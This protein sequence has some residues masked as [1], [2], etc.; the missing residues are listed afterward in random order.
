MNRYKI[1]ILIFSVLCPFTFII[2]QTYINELMA[3]NQLSSF[4][5]FFE[6][7][8]WVELYHEGGV[9]N[10]EGH[11]LSDR[12]DSLTKWQFPSTNAGLTTILPNGFLLV[13]LDNDSIQGENHAEF[14]LSPDGE[15]IY[16]TAPDGVTILD[17]LTFPPQQTDIHVHS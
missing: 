7:D 14:K 11:F 4:D 10:L 3:S 13:W 9:L 8:D 12:L 17:S 2:G 6:S 16:L 5:D 1:I 15:G